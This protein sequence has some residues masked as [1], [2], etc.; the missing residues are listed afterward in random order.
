MLAT[1][2]IISAIALALWIERRRYNKRT[3]RVYNVVCARLER[4]LTSYDIIVL[5]STFSP[6]LSVKVMGDHII[7]LK[8]DGHDGKL[9]QEDLA[10]H[11]WRPLDDRS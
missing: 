9:A 11:T 3:Q 10:S 4:S 8:V 1:L 2:S 5:L 6:I 7:E